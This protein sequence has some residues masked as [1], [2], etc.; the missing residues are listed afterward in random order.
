[1]NRDG[2]EDNEKQSR[3]RVRSR[4]G[5]L[6]DDHQDGLAGERDALGSRLDGAH[7][8]MQDEAEAEIRDFELHHRTYRDAK[9]L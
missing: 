3:S 6:V 9:R 2:F 5:K 7:V 4:R 8:A 1:M